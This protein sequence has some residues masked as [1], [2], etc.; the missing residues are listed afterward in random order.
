MPIVATELADTF[1]SQPE[2]NFKVTKFL[3]LEIKT[4]PTPAARAIEAPYV[5]AILYY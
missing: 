4:A 2:R 3:T 5:G 1:T